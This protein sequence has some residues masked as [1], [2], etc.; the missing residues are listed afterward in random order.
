VNYVVFDLEWNQCPYGKEHE[1]RKLPFEII[2]IGAVRLDAQRNVIDSFRRVIRPRVYKKLHHR[3]REIVRLTAEELKNGMDFADA[4]RDFLLWAGRDAVFCTWGCV[5]L[6]EFQRNLQF[7]HQLKLLPGPFHY[8]D[9]QKLFSIA[10]ENESTCRALSH[11]IEMLGMEKDAEF[12]SA[13]ADAR[14]TARIFR[15]IPAELLPEND[16][17][18]VFQNPK[19][20]TEEIHTVYGTFSLFISREFASKEEAMADPEVKAVHC[21]KCGKKSHRKIRWFAAGSQKYLCHAIC[22]V[23]GNLQGVIRMRRSE[24]GAIYVKKVVAQCTDAQAE[25]IRRRRDE[26]RARRQR[27]RHRAEALPQQI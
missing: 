17:L 6:N 9:V 15:K 4:A 13:S 8:Y 1:N 11:A 20:K 14:Y 23:H 26:L 27:K 12:H 21:C 5:D 25:Q 18:N 3:T 19:T 10:Y 22:P 2:E 7:Y 16:S 24:S